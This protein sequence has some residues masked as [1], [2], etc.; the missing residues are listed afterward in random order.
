MKIILDPSLYNFIPGTPGSG[1]IDFSS[2][3]GY[4][5][6]HCLAVI[7]N[8][9]NG[10]TLIYSVAGG[11]S[12]GSLPL[13]GTS[14]FFNYDTSSMGALDS[15]TV[16]YDDPNAVQQ[17]SGTVDV[18]SI[19]DTTIA[20][21]TITQIGIST[22]VANA[23]TNSAAATN[24]RPYRTM[25]VQF[26]N[27]TGTNIVFEGSNDNSTFTTLTARKFNDAGN[28]AISSIPITSGDFYA[29]PIDCA[30]VR[31][32]VTA[33][34][35]A[36]DIF[37]YFSQIPYADVIQH[38]SLVS[39]NG[40]TIDYG[41]GDSS[42]QTIR[43]IPANDSKVLLND[44]IVSS[45]S[46][47]SALGNNV[48]TG[49][50]SSIDVTNYRSVGL[51]ITG[52][53]G[54]SAGAVT[55]EISNDNT[56]WTTHVLIPPANSTPTPTTGAFSVAANTS[57]YLQASLPFRYFRVRIVIGFTGGTVTAIA[58]FSP[59]HYTGMAI[60]V[61]GTVSANATVNNATLVNSFITDIAS[62]AITSTQTSTSI[63]NAGYQSFNM[64]VF[65]TAVSGTNP[66]MDVVFQGS[67]DNG[68]TWVDIYHMPRITAAGT[69][70]T[71]PLKTI[72]SVF[73]I[74]RT[75]GGTTPSF[76]NSVT[77]Q[78]HSVDGP[79]FYSFFDRAVVPNTLN[80]TT[81]SFFVEGS[82]KFF[83]AINM[84]AI[85]TT[86]PAFQMEGS[87]DNSS[88]Y[89]IGTPLTGV[90]NSTVVTT[91]SPG[92]MSRFIRARVSTAGSGAT[93]GYVNL[94]GTDL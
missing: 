66:T 58:R 81:S 36:F 60:P 30:Y 78:V 18:G 37:A 33:F 85:T 89:A 22:A 90:A 28:P 47:Q 5:L 10:G 27:G 35:I 76:T 54:I 80:S 40:R 25:F 72:Y 49:N 29:V 92:P 44:Y 61:I 83:M 84:G 24:A 74:V 73:R 52:S 41:T 69:Y 6:G 70:Y 75:L 31:V 82:S 12:V 16:I 2:F 34:I 62:A 14:I 56:N 15:L 67:A 88:W 7:N 43:I 94:K 91:I 57:Y 9:F 11:A 51:T 45:P 77:R 63:S 4:Q 48:L 38:Q 8:D 46:G 68:T 71:G 55:A 23:L 39:P 19:P 26:R 79:I 87:E 59:L 13:S 50:T 32:R 21:G 65:V 64:T 86:A 53:A 42:G 93:L 20:N 17:V 3:G 1:R